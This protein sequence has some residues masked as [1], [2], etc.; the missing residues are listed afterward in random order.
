[1]TPSSDRSPGRWQRF[2]EYVRENSFPITISAL[3]FLA[4]LVY[5]APNIVISVG[6]GEAGVLWSRFFGGTV[7]VA[8][9][10][11]PFVGR[12]EANAAGDPV[13]LHENL[14]HWNQDIRRRGYAVYPYGEGL[15]LIWPWDRMY[16]YNIRFQQV[17]HTYDVLTNDGLDVK[18]EITIQWKP[19]EGDLGKLHRD[20]GPDYVNTLVIPIVGAY[21]REEIAHYGPDAL[22]SPTRLVIQEAI[23][24]KTKRA[25]M[26]RFYPE[27]KRESYVIV[28]DILIRSITLPAEVRT[29]IQEK[30]VQK[31]L[32]ESYKYRLDRERQEAERKSIEAEGIQRFQAKINSTISEGYLKWKGIDAT[33]ELAKSQNAKIVVIGTGKDGLPIILGGLEP[34]TPAAPGAAP[35]P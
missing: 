17:S 19:I 4:L 2:K 30:V 25:L 28:E 32:A 14:N 15:R 22:Y 33:L 29:A 18:A 21:A 23:R 1:M 12:I 11:R 26:S 24:T 35:R 6:P 20:I 31:H 16:I 10:G 5:F 13:K 7:T 34:G 8:S 9:D 3:I 27:N